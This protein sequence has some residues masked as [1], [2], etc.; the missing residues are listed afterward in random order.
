M[1]AERSQREGVVFLAHNS[2]V[3]HG[4]IDGRGYMAELWAFSTM[5]V[6]WE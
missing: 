6:R 3:G 2:W 4:V 5:Y 1:V